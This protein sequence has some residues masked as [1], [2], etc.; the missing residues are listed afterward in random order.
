VAGTALRE[1]LLAARAEDRL[2]LLEEHLR[3]QVAHVLRLDPERVDARRPLGTMGL[4]SLMAIE[5]RNRLEAGTGLSFSA[6]LIWTYPTVVSLAAHLAERM[7]VSPAPA[8]AIA[9][10]ATGGADAAPSLE[11]LSEHELAGMLAQKLAAL[12]KRF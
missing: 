3:E 4:D 12:E 10:E 8:A 5:L 7:E 11:D 9:A 2:A 1:T 6:T